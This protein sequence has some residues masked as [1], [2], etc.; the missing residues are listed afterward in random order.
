MPKICHGCP[1]RQEAV[2]DPFRFRIRVRVDF[3]CLKANWLKQP[4][5]NLPLI[6]WHGKESDPLWSNT[7]F[8]FHDYA[9]KSGLGTV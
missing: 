3:C 2:I 9:V 4:G 6:G 7:A 8:S 5:V 1:G